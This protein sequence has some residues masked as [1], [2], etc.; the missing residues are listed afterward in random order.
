MKK[1][2]WKEDAINH[3]KECDPEE[4]CGVIGVKNSQEKY[5]PC[6][7]ISNELKAESFVIDPVDWADI[8]DSVD[9]I[10]GIVHSHPQDVFKFSESDKH[11]CKA[12]DLT[13]YLVSPKSDKIAVIKPDEIDA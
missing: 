9:E 12:I 6:K 8:E 1:Y 2:T 5:Y 3:A 11:S 4:S 7:N 10:I 13:F